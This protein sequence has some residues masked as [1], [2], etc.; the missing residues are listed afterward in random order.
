M[1][2]VSK[3]NRSKLAKI[4][5]KMQYFANFDYSLLANIC[6]FKKAGQGDNKT[7]NDCFIM[8]DTETSKKK[9]VKDN[10]VCAWTL[11]I[12][13]EHRNIVTLYGNKPSEAVQALQNVHNNMKGF[14]TYCYIHNMAY[15]WVFLRKFFFLYMGYPK[16]QL[17]TKPHYPILFEFDNGIILKDSLI[18]A[19][20][21]LERWANDMDVEHKKAVGKWDYNAIRNQDCKFTTDELTYIENDTLAGVECLDKLCEM[22]HKHVYSMPYTATGIPREEFR[23]EG[24]KHGA[25]EKYVAMAPTYEQYQK[26]L[27]LFHGGYTHAN[28]FIVG[29]TLDNVEAFDFSSSYPFCMLSMRYPMERFTPCSNRSI[30][31]ILKQSDK[32]AFMFKLVMIKVNLRDFYKTEMPAL[33]YSKCIKCVNPVIDNGRIICADYIEIYLNEVDLSVINSQYHAIRTICCEVEYAYK[34]YL[35]RW[36]TDIIYRLFKEKSELKGVDPVLYNLQKG[37]LNSSYGMSVQK[38]CRELL[39]EC[40]DTGEYSVTEKDMKEEYDKQVKKRNSILSYAWGVWVTSYAFR[41]LFMLGSC[42]DHEN[43]GIWAYSDTD[44]CYSTK[45]NKNKVAM[46]NARAVELL[47]ANGYGPVTVNDK[48]YCLGVAEFDGAYKKFRTLGAKRYCVVKEDDTIKITV[49][50][51]PKKTGSKCLESIEDFK[52]GFIF[53]GNKT[54]K[55]THEYIYIDNIYTDEDGNETGDSVNLVPCDYLLDDVYQDWD[56]ALSETVGILSYEEY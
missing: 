24:K 13:A 4:E 21:S 7:Y 19:Q 8:L 52:K 14:N 56:K 49:A 2:L 25:H 6:A 26:L 43:G 34:D 54:G 22:L 39:E 37:K 47:K 15:D 30:D 18:L 44:S 50:G 10:H 1:S 42:V 32:Y 5:Y 9:N 40:F 3:V 17:S 53:E 41:N 36:F 16:K 11:S 27:M 48:S 23:V 51:V 31:D 33:Q 35:P 38:V 45:W 46:Y 29:Q 12:R 28:R 20:R 55:L